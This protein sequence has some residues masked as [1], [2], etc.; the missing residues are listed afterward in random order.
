MK[1]R[2]FSRVAGLATLSAAALLLVAGCP[3]QPEQLEAA[4]VTAGSYA[5][6]YD[7]AQLI[8]YSL[9]ETRDEEGLWYTFDVPQPDWYT[10]P[11]VYEVNE[12]GEWTAVIENVTIDEVITT[13]DVV[14]AVE[15]PTA[16][17]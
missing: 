12:N 15:A 13:W 10:G 16:A 4:G 5:V 7:G 14:P 9:P 1:L 11:A 8:V 6:E 17:D 2:Q 3:L